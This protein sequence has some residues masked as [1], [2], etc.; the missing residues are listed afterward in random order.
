[1][2]HHLLSFIGKG[3][4]YEK[5]TYRLSDRH[6]P[7]SSALFGCALLDWLREGDR[8]VDRVTF[9]G[10]HGSNFEVLFHTSGLVGSG[11]DAV[12]DQ[13][14]AQAGRNAVQ[15]RLLA[16]LQAAVS[17]AL[18]LPVELRLIPTAETPEEQVEVV[19]LLAQGIAPGD[20]VTL[21]VTHGLRHL[22]MLTL[23]AA[24]MLRHVRRARVE[25]I[26]YGALDLRPKDEHRPQEE[27]PAPVV[28]LKGILNVADWLAAFAVFER[29]GDFGMFAPLLRQD[30]GVPPEVGE[31]L[32]AAAAAE[33]ATRLLAAERAIGEASRHAGGEWR[34]L[35][36]LFKD[37]LV[38][39]IDCVHCGSLYDRQRQLALLHLKH[40]D[41]LRAAIF[42]YEA[43]LTG[44]TQ[45]TLDPN[46]GQLLDPHIH[47]DRDFCRQIIE[48]CL[49]THAVGLDFRHHRNLDH[50][51]A[52]EGAFRVLRNIRNALAHVDESQRRQYASL[53]DDQK[54]L[55]ESMQEVFDFILPPG[56][57]EW[58][59]FP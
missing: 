11:L 41:P 31:G 48:K 46:T 21:D 22:P 26:Y 20:S 7:K 50:S 45:Q 56:P 43:V 47:R 6:E 2:T 39:R 42:G 16:K 51:M 5:A 25:A 10:T 53:L 40:D 57:L 54:R 44:I 27:I 34:G 38:E 29:T 23:A 9:F 36:G 52:K 58:N 19:R 24:L 49:H 33:R 32:A 3:E 14:R 18:R 1:M 28:D 59:I 12:H 17:D 13:L 37:A 35:S 8:P 55:A 15:E 4:E 30:D